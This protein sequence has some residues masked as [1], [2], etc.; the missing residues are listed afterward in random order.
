MQT[1][2]QTVTYAPQTRKQVSALLRYLVKN[3]IDETER[4][5]PAYYA[6]CS[7]VRE[8]MRAY[9][10]KHPAQARIK[11]PCPWQI[12]GASAMCQDIAVKYSIA[13]WTVSGDCTP[14]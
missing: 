11:G 14:S 12:T 4:K 1:Q 5:T 2:T 6:E 9:F 7:V 10:A 8:L 3:N 13:S